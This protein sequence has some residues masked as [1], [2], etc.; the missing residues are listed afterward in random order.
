VKAP[1]WSP[2]DAKP[3]ADGI[4]PKSLCSQFNDLKTIDKTVPLYKHRACISGNR[5]VT[6][7]PLITA[8]FCCLWFSA[9]K[10]QGENVLAAG[11]RTT[12]GTEFSMGDRLHRLVFDRVDKVDRHLSLSRSVESS[13][14]VFRQSRSGFQPLSDASVSRR[15]EAASSRFRIGSAECSTQAPVSRPCCGFADRSVTCPARRTPKRLLH[16]AQRGMTQ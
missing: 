13:V 11:G 10:C 15:V 1:C 4:A 6:G 14:P 7:H 3:E 12:A 2:G 5:L 9:L 8:I 16:A